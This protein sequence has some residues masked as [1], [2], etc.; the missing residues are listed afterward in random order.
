MSITQPSRS[1]TQRPQNEGPSTA[2]HLHGRAPRSRIE[3]AHI[4]I[5]L[6]PKLAASCIPSTAAS[7][8]PTKHTNQ[9]HQPDAQPAP[10]APPTRQSHGIPTAK[11]TMTQP[12]ARSSRQAGQTPT[13]FHTAH[14]YMARIEADRYRMVLYNEAHQDRPQDLYRIKPQDL[15]KRA[16][17]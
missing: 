9:A 4:K 7:G 3:G 14:G 17:R 1:A 11:H 13:R 6:C 16:A 5:T 8:T 15:Y 12:C 10:M 2:Q